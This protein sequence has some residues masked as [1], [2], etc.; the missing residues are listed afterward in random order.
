MSYSS[1]T[2]VLA[3]DDLAQNVAPEVSE[4]TVV[5]PA[6]EVTEEIP[7]KGKDTSWEQRRINALTRRVHEAER[8]AALAEQGRAQAPEEP[9][10]A[11]TLTPELFN[12]EVERVASKQQFDAT[13][14][15]IYN[16]GIE[17]LPGFET[18]LR[19]FVQVGGLNPVLIE[20]AIESGNPHKLLFD[21]GGDLDEAARILELPP[22][23]MAAAVAK[24]AAAQRA[25][26]KKVTSAPAPIR[27]LTPA[28]GPTED[29]EKMSSQEWRVWREKQVAAKRR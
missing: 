12:S 20:A 26:T 8:R 21:L 25:E 29:P 17:E 11:P 2:A 7:V 3:D 16:Q 22:V 9:G 5:E 23:R 14:T 1:E 4:T 18:R 28:A 6:S 13:C 15:A 19:N 10:T 27:P 24:F